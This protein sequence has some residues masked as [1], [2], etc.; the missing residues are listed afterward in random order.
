VILPVSNSLGLNYICVFILVAD[1]N[2]AELMSIG[3]RRQ[4]SKERMMSAIDAVISG[5][6]LNAT[7]KAN[8]APK[9]TLKRYLLSSNSVVHDFR[10][11]VKVSH[12]YRP[13]DCD[14]GL[15]SD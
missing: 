4:W 10:R 3:K 14:M 13:C 11:L 12:F 8:S 7:A 5:M 2:R 9:A 6:G 15:S 1:A